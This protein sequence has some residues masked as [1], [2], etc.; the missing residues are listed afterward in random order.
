MN[1][2]FCISD[3]SKYRSELMGWAIVWIMMLHFTFI[4]I[5]PLG[6]IAQYGFAGVDI[7]MLVSGFGLYFSLDNNNSIHAYIKKR[8]IRI[9]PTYYLIGIFSSIFIFNDNI[10]SYFI[11]NSTIGFWTNG[12]YW[13]WYV[14]SIVVLYLFAP[15]IKK[16][17]DNS[18]NIMISSIAILLLMISFVIVS[19]EFVDAKDPH[20]FFLYRTPEF[21]F[22]IICASWTKN[23]ITNKYFYYTL[24]L[25]IPIFIFLFP[26]HHEIF[27]YKYLSLAFLLPSFIVFFATFSKII[28]PINPILST[29]G[30]ASL[31]VYLIQS[32]FFEA[33]ITR[34]LTIDD[35]WHDAITIVLILTCILLGILVHWI[36]NKYILVRK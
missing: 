20:F 6:F 7:F 5:K 27:N 9:F 15:I 2:N 36:I 18:Y 25:G 1:Y 21:I 22:G 33:I 24:I 32:L 26:K 16:A 35:T 29:I 4:T 28:K 23:G 19:H 31:E 10:L 30:R 11:R 34:K 12:I 14:P 8:I 13:E 17:I 3:I